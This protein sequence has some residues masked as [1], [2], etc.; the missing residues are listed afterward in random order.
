M[1][2][3]PRL[4]DA[5][6][7][8]I[9]LPGPES[10][11]KTTIVPAGVNP[12]SRDRFRQYPSRNLRPNT[13]VEILEEAD[14]GDPYRLIE[15]EE[16]MV[17]KDG[18]IEAILRSRS[19]AVAGLNWDVVPPKLRL[20][21]EGSEEKAAEIARFCYQALDSCEFSELVVDLMDAVCKPFAVDWITWAND[22]KGRVVPQ[23]FKRIPTKHIRWAFNADEI[24]VYNPMMPMSP[25]GE[26]GE[27]LP[28][29]QTVRAIDLSRRDHPTRAGVGRTLLWPYFFKLTIIKDMVA[30]G[31]RFGIPPRV[32]RIDQSDFDNAERYQKFRNAMSDFGQDLSAVISKNSELDVK[33]IATRD[34][35][36]VFAGQ[37][38]YFDKWMAWK[39]LGHE[40]S[41]Q[42]SPGQGQLGITAAMDV[43]QDIKEADCRWLAGII[44]R[45][46]L[47]PIVGWNFGWEAVRAHLVPALQFDYELPRDLKGEATVLQTIMTT[48][49]DLTVSKQKIRDDYGIPAPVGEEDSD[50]GDDVLR[51]GSAQAGGAPT[52]APDP[53]VEP[54]TPADDPSAPDAAPEAVNGARA[55]R[56]KAPKGQLS[57]LTPEQ[58]QEPV[59]ELVKRGK[60]GAKKTTDSWMRTLRSILRQAAAD[61]L[62]FPQTRKLIVDAYPELDVA[63]L[64]KTLQEQILLTRLHGRNS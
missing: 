15:L 52:G 25:G 9:P 50:E 10:P 22:E 18:K 17:E 6:G 59:D 56:R 31:E 48:F 40:L 8:E 49:P 23:G 12:D 58:K 36:E 1:A 7:T 41:S 16:E 63:S 26:W 3:S 27:P 57:L 5:T 37:I 53:A 32:L 21:D 20:A 34:G 55:R 29:Y 13:I 46:I 38:D 44:K 54:L 11:Q 39:V 24:R 51:P 45:D 42:S 30:Y 60:A 33:V 61:E 2:G 47:T 28:P 19:S 64:D 4:F 62:D 35:V 43:R 14:N